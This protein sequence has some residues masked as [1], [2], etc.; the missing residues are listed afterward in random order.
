M[1]PAVVRSGG[2]R[3]VQARERRKE[4]KTAAPDIAMEI[5]ICLAAIRS[6]HNPLPHSRSHIAATACEDA[7]PQQAGFGERS[8]I[9][10]MSSAVKAQVSGPCPRSSVIDRFAGLVLEWRAG[11]RKR[12]IGFR[13][14]DRTI[15]D[16][17]LTRLE[18]T[19]R[20]ATMSLHKRAAH[21]WS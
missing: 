7:D 14:D 13:L 2:D 17:G 20:E 1:H 16:I 15:R 18:V 10:T 8:A 11:N 9:V 21:R 3:R 5:Q 19:Y 12:R 6:R 4:G